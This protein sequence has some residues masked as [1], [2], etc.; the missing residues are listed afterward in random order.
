MWTSELPLKLLPKAIQVFYVE[1]AWE[2]KEDLN[3]NF[4]HIELREPELVRPEYYS[5]FPGHKLRVV[6]NQNPN[7]YRK[8]Y[9]EEGVRRKLVK[10]SLERLVNLEDKEYKGNSYRYDFLLRDKMHDD[11]IDGYDHFLYRVPP[12]NIV[13]RYFGYE[14]LDDG[15]E[16]RDLIKEAIPKTN[17]VSIYEKAPF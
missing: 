11:I 14:P 13:R 3:E 2:L 1:R 7:W 16:Q 8:L 15:L 9:S 10:K 4:L 17:G 5:A 12:N 6:E